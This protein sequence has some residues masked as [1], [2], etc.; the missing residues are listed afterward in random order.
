MNRNNADY[1]KGALMSQYKDRLDYK[2]RTLC[3]N[4][5][6]TM[7][8]LADEKHPNLEKRLIPIVVYRVVE[9]V[10]YTPGNKMGSLANTLDYGYTSIILDNVPSKILE[11]ANDI[12]YAIT[13]ELRNDKA[14]HNLDGDL[15][16]VLFLFY[17]TTH[18]FKVPILVDTLD[19][20]FKMHYYLNYRQRLITDTYNIFKSVIIDKN[21]VLACDDI[22][23]VYMP[24]TVKKLTKTMKDLTHEEY[25]TL[26]KAWY[27]LKPTIYDEFKEVVQGTNL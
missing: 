9:Y 20:F 18:N 25:L 1:V 12:V 22:Y 24:E 6:D 3:S 5:I 27:D 2:D 10:R 21:G 17:F 11:D 8:Y 19:A 15:K 13:Y 16:D 23:K 26:F 14:L 7:L 4:I